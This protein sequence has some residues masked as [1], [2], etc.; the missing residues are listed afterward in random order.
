MKTASS[1]LDTAELR[2]LA[3][4]IEADPRTV[5]KL[6]LGVEVRG[7][8]GRRVRRELERLGYLS[9]Q[10]PHEAPAKGDAD[11]REEA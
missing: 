7:L 8:V 6:L 4:R 1:T 3:V 9:A 10:A 11:E 2:D 5:R